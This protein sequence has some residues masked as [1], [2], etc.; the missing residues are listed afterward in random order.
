M[1]EEV[2]LITADAFRSYCFL[3]ITYCLLALAPQ[4]K[5][6]LRFLS[7]TDSLLLL[8]RLEIC[9]SAS[10]LEQNYTSTIKCM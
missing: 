8:L 7:H 4:Q 10:V 2:I 6:Q 5:G 9:P 1:V 3:T